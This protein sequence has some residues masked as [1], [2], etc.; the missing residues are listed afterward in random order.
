[1]KFDL[2]PNS[3][4]MQALAYQINPIDRSLNKNTITQRKDDYSI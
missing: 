4:S 2:N 3:Q 1:M